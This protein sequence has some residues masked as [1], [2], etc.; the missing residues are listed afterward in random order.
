MGFVIDRFTYLRY[1][2]ATVTLRIPKPRADLDTIEVSSVACWTDADIEIL[3]A[4]GRRALDI[5]NSDRQ[6]T[7][8]R[9]QV[10]FTTSLVVL[11]ALASLWGAVAATDSRP[12]W[13]IYGAAFV[14]SALAL[15]GSLAVFVLPVRAEVMHPA[16][17]TS[18]TKPILRRTALDYAAMAPAMNRLNSTLTMVFREATLYLSYGAV[19]FVLVWILTGQLSSE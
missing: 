19:G 9:S 10:A 3:L 2:L 14:F 16:L 18:Y 8:S 12:V 13:V 15:G 17:L 7:R 5:S 6:T 11:G 1:A 4:E